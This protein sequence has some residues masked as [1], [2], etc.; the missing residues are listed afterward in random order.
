MSRFKSDYQDPRLRAIRTFCKGAFG[1]TVF[2]IPT[3]FLATSTFGN[4]SPAQAEEI[5]STTIPVTTTTIDPLVHDG[6]IGPDV[7][8]YCKGLA[9]QLP[10]LN[11]QLRT[12]Q[13]GIIEEAQS[14][15]DII[16]YALMTECG[17]TPPMVLSGMV[18]HLN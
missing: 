3:G 2:T 5:I 15:F 6:R 4:I 9:N 17:W 12:G 16:A 18:H 13:T 14:D 7:S 10:A 8:L 11:D 1:L